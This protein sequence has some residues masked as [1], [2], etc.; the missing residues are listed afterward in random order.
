MVHEIRMAFGR[1]PK[2]NFFF[3]FTP[4]CYLLLGGDKSSITLFRPQ[5]HLSL[6]TGGAFLIGFSEA[7]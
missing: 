2:F 5:G 6:T 1:R 3:C 7:V 4:L